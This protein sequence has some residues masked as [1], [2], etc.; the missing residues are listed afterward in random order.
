MEIKSET[1]YTKNIKCADVYTES[2]AEYI[3]P[4]YLGDVRKIL[5]TGAE[6]RPSG[7]FAGDDEVEFSGIVVYTVVYLDADNDISSVEFTSEYDYS[8]K[9]SGEKYKDSL[10][11]TRVSNY[12]IRLIGH[13][14]YLQ[15]PL[16]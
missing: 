7:R 15:R 5:F 14:K 4:D 1:G 12:Q 2:T 8:V 13:A 16:S 3:L 11:D 6:V 9:C 10:A